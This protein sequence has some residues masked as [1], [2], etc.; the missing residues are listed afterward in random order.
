MWPLEGITQCYN[1][2]VEINWIARKH[3][4]LFPEQGLTLCGGIH[5]EI[6][7][8]AALILLFSTA[9]T[10]WA[11]SGVHTLRVVQRSKFCPKMQQQTTVMK[12]FRD[13]KCRGGLKETVTDVSKVVAVIGSH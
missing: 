11:L 13:V 6:F 10:E 2:Y 9:E 7:W 8:K 1:I 5:L 3:Q 4:N 12:I